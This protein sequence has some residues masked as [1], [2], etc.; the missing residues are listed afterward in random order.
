V[1]GLVQAGVENAVATCGTALGEGHVRL[2]SRFAQRA[3][4]AFDSDEAGARAAERAFAFHEQYPLQAVVMILPQ[5]LD[6]AD[7]VAKHGAEAVREAA[8]AARPLVE[9]MVRRTVER[10]DLSTV[11]GQSAAV[12][13]ALPILEG[14]SDPVRRSEYGHMLADLAGVSETSVM[15][16][17]GRRLGGRPQEVAKTLK[18]VSAQDKV[19]REMLKLLARDEEIYVAYVGRLEP[20]HFRNATNKRAFAAL[21]EA[22]GDIGVLAGGDDPKMAATASAL[23]VEPLDGDDDAQFAERVWTRLQEFLLKGRSDALRL[24]LQKLNPT[25]DPEYED[26]FRELVAIDGDLRRLRDGEPGVA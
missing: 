23:A 3:V 6:P 14:L 21:K 16:A 1:I 2:L 18:R 8:A 12:A 25:V 4:L 15:Q 19:E 26:L 10:H 17:L 22:E 24:R 7:F 9:Y 5:G 13:D 11:E 20:D